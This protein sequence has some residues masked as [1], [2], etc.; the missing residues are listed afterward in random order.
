MPKVARKVSRTRRTRH[1]TRPQLGLVCITHSEECRFRTVTRSR[2]LAM[3]D[4]AAR[5]AALETLYWANLARLHGAISFCRRNDIRLYRAT[6]GLFPMSDD[7]LGTAVLESL[8]ANLSSIGR[9]VRRLGIRVVLHPDQFVVLNSESAS[10]AATSRLIL[11]KHGRAFDL[12]KLP[13]SPWSAMII[14]GGKSG[15]GDE[16]IRAIR[17]LRPSVRRRLVLENDEYAYGAAEIL[18]VC[19][20]AGVPMV[21]DCHHHVIKEQLDSYEHPNVRRF[22]RAARDTW[23]DPSWQLVHV[24]NGAAG[25]RDRNHSEFIDAIPSAYAAVPWIEVEARGKERA[26]DRLRVDLAEHFAGKRLHRVT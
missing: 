11:E 23:P 3:P 25:F 5:R 4:D 18:D 2:Y 15:R 12:L 24:S 19:R 20:R 14:H 16:L 21:F 17:D 6:S 10:V 1:T 9:R 26:I 13:R 7:A 22:T 8:A